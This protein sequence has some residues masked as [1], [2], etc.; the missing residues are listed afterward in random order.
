MV[1]QQQLRFMEM[2]IRWILIWIF[3]HNQLIIFL[4]IK[5]LILIRYLLQQRWR[6][7]ILIIRYSYLLIFWLCLNINQ[8]FLFRWYSVLLRSCLL[9]L[10]FRWL[11]IQGGIIICKFRFWLHQQQLVLNL[12]IQLLERVFQLQFHWRKCWMHH[13][14]LQWFYQ[15]AFNRQVEFR[16]LNRI[17][18]NKHYQLRYHIILH[19]L[20]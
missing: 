15:M 18:P 4:I 20:K 10:L 6:S 16:V 13:L 9:H 2:D 14:L 8:R 12:R 17:I 1:Q 11:I 19:E 3:Y 5:I 7:W